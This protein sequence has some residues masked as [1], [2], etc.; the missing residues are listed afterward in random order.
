MAGALLLSCA[1]YPRQVLGAVLLWTCC[2]LDGC[3]GEV[4]RLKRLASPWG[5]RYDVIAD[6]IVHAAVFTAIAVQVRRTGAGL[7]WITPSVLMLTGVPASMYSAWRL[8]LSK[9]EASRPPSTRAFERIASRD[10]IYIVLVLT[11]IQR[12][13]WFV[14]GAAVGSHIFWIALWW[15]AR[16]GRGL[17]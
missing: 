9:P 17:A 13:E 1:D 15:T 7:G 16:R 8:I 2:I 12:L 10:F 11:L 14:W 4:A 5:G 3:D 6:N